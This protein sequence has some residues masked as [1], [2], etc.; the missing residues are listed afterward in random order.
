MEN[1]QMLPA[2]AGDTVA[3]QITVTKVCKHCCKE[4]PVS[5]FFKNKEQ[6]TTH[7]K[8][9]H[10]LAPKTCRT[11]GTTFEGKCHQYF[12]SAT[13]RRAQRPQTFKFCSH[14][15]K[16]FGPLSHLSTRYC[17]MA[18]KCA[19]QRKAYPKPRQA[20]TN[21]ARAAQAAVARAIRAGLLHRPVVCSECG[22]EGRIEAAHRDYDEPLDVRWLCRSCHA[23]W[24]WAEP[25]GG[26][27]KTTT[28]T[29]IVNM[30]GP[31]RLA[32]SCP[33]A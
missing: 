15:H 33:A 8:R 16:L 30:K 31:S 24:D 13:C 29:R 4:L 10:G 25:K 2:G 9:C 19:G 32:V 6:L 21:K 18:C 28:G 27:V 1:F 12:C 22:Y 7:C 11:C 23:R 5:N 26:T 3:A 20:P 14:C 17:S